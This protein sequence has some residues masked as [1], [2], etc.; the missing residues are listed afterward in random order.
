M[1]SL[2]VTIIKKEEYESFVILDIETFLE[3]LRND[4]RVSS[5][6]KNMDVG[7]FKQ[8]VDDGVSPQQFIKLRALNDKEQGAL[9]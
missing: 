7:E 2:R 5:K 9:S 4:P 6:Y 1:E 3:K 8:F